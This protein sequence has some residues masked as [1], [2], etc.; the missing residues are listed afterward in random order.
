MDREERR[1]SDRIT[2]G[3]TVSL[4]GVSWSRVS[5][6]H[7]YAVTSHGT[8]RARTRTRARV[9]LMKLMKLR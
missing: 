3:V 5:A 6:A 9:E 8:T 4:S 1:I 2:V 7:G